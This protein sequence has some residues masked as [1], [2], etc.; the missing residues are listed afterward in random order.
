MIR[1]KYKL[2]IL[3]SISIFIA[4]AQSFS[5]KVIDKKSGEP[6]PYATVQTG[7]N[8]GVITN[9]DG[10]FTITETALKKVKDS[11]YISSMGYE[12]KG[13]SL[14]NQIENVI[15][16]SPATF[17]LKEIFLSTN[18]LTAIEIIEKVKE[19]LEKNYAVGLTQKK[20]FFRQSE[21]N[22][23]NKVDFGFQESTI[24][25]L[26]KELMDS[27]SRSIPKESSYYREVVGDFYGDY[28]KHKLRIDKAAELYD[29]SKD[30]STDGISKKLEQIFK[31]NVKPD[32]YLKIKSGIFG[33]KVELDSI[34]TSNEETK[35]V[36]EK[37]D[38]KDHEA[39]LGQIKGRISEL[40]AQLFFKEDSKID[41]LEKS[42]RYNFTLE[43]YTNI[44][45]STVY[46]L[47]FSPKGNKD[48]KGVLYVNT[49]D[50]AIMR[51]EFENVRPLTKFGLLGITFRNNV[52][53][54][55]MLFKKDENGAYGPHFIELD[56]GNFVGIARPLKV[57]E[58]NKHVKGPR[59]Q[60]ELSLELDF[61]VTQLTK[62]ELVVFN[63]EI[64]TN[65]IYDSLIENKDVK[66]SYLS[67]YDPNFWQEYTIMEPNAA[68]QSFK[69]SIK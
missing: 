59:K 13:V 51:L 47:K 57:I 49:E 64:T 19:N 61:Q 5:A 31:E 66:A 46:I 25:E 29:K 16:L 2:C 56:D 54:G 20:I 11:I 36:E 28:N 22:K 21:F 35:E 23:M 58:K 55:K 48:F 24:E 10:V 26:N 34:I 42:N 18:P 1:I 44:D 4:N 40:Y 39:F 17:E 14:E 67:E 45:E 30:L 6:I 37:N 50:Y 15:V 53:R 38:S 32:S 12:K 69:V 9:E 52:Y 63:S 65:S 41:I 3:F 43:D 60:N 68:I 33:T 7:K 62:Y 27:I 8:Q